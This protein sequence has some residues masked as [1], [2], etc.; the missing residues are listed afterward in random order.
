MTATRR[1]SAATM[2]AALVKDGR[3]TKA[4]A[5]ALDVK[6]LIAA[7]NADDPTTDPTPAPKQAKAKAPKAKPAPKA[8]KA[9]A[10][11]N[12]PLCGCGCGVPTVTAKARFLSGHDARF[13]GLV[14]RGERVLTDEESSLVTPALQAKI[15]KIRETAN[16][17][18]ATKAA[19]EAAKAA[20]KA[21]YAAAM[22]SAV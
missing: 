13:A 15:D 5:A 1:P 21:A 16:R 11:A 3:F 7:Y 10:P 12:F 17:K 22:A 14:G 20:A 18:A 9:A 4:E 8:P 2:R 19:Q 6:A